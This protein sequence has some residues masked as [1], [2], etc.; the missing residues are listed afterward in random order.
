MASKTSN[1]VVSVAAEISNIFYEEEPIGWVGRSQA[2]A[3]V[4]P[5]VQHF[6]GLGDCTFSSLSFGQIKI[7]HHGAKEILEM[8]TWKVSA[9]LLQGS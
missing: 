9:C 3:I 5:Q 7:F 4:F 2:V 1:F 8:T 6:G